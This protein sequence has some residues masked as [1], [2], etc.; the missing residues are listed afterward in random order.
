V[1]RRQRRFATHRSQVEHRNGDRA[2]WTLEDVETASSSGTASGTA[3]WRAPPLNHG[4]RSTTDA[5]DRDAPAL[6]GSPPARRALRSSLAGLGFETPWRSAGLA[7]DIDV[8]LRARHRA[9]GTEE[10]V[11]NALP[12]SIENEWQVL[13][14]TATADR[15]KCSFPGPS[16]CSVAAPGISYSARRRPAAPLAGARRASERAAGERVIADLVP[17]RTPARFRASRPQRA[18]GPAGRWRSGSGSADRRRASRVANRAA[19]RR[20]RAGRNTALDAPKSAWQQI[21]A[22]GSQSRLSV[23]RR[24]AEAFTRAVFAYDRR[25]PR[26]AHGGRGAKRSMVRSGSRRRHP[27]GQPQGASRWSASLRPAP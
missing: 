17:R 1:L 19:A 5:P 15:L 2:W 20:P 18:G 10:F 14:S 27:H 21:R 3:K 26:E 16:P 23:R 4:G 25:Q 7:G 12:E 6:D 9:P 8:L 24:R 22:F 11:C 13:S